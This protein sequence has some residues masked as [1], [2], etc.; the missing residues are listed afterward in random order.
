MNLSTKYFSGHES[1]YLR[2]GWLR[3]GLVQVAKYPDIFVKR[4]LTLA[5]NELGV[6]ANMVKSIRYWL[7]FF[8]LIY[9]DNKKNAYFIEDVAKLLLEQDPYF[10]NISSIWLLHILST[11]QFTDTR[12]KKSVVESAN[13]CIWQMIFSEGELSAFDKDKLFAKISAR[14][15]EEGTTYAPA[16]TKSGLN[17]F[18]STYHSD[19]ANANPEENIISPLTKLNII[20]KFDGNL[21]RFRSIS[22]S[23]ISPYLIYFILFENQ[24]NDIIQLEDAFELV[25]LSI[26]I[27]LINLRQLI[28][29]LVYDGTVTFDRAAGLNNIRITK[30]LELSEL[31]SRMVGGAR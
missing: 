7:E 8:R 17:T 13:S 25:R 29:T 16:T 5:I 10:Q 27:D 15:K 26:K 12:K 14:L 18:F 2:E 1:F 9:K 20:T 4:N 6:G 30:K 22:H 24:N 31:I 28:D 19:K 3:K 23:E 11:Q 21:Y